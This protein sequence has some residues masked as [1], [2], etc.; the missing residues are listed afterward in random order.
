ML[1]ANCETQKK[2][3][4]TMTEPS[5]TKPKEYAEALFSPVP[6]TS[7]G[8]KY[9]CR[10]CFPKWTINS[11]STAEIKTITGGTKE[12]FAGYTWAMQHLKAKHPGY[13][14]LNLNDSP[15][16]YI[17]AAAKDT[18]KW[19]ECVSCAT[20]PICICENESI[21]NLMHYAGNNVLTNECFANL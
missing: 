12:K 17:S 21:Q 14:N 19:I 16:L 1:T 10:L 4:L 2:T 18:L 6:D 15:K 13:E 11:Q 3:N 8:F 9:I 5:K 7:N 20:E